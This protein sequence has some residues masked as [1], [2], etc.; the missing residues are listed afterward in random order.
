MTFLAV[1]EDAVRRQGMDPGAVTLS[2]AEQ[3]GLAKRIEKWLKRGWRSDWWP[4]L[5]VV[6]QREYRATWAVGTTYAADAE[7]YY[8]DGTDEGYFVSL[9]GTNVGNTPSFA[10]ATAWWEEA[11][12]DFVSYVDFDQSWETNEIDS[13][14][15]LGHVFDEDP[16][17]HAESAPLGWCEVQGERL[18]VRY[19]APVRPWLKFRKMPPQFTRTAYAGG[20]TYAA[21]AVVYGSDG[22]C[23]RSLAG[24]NTG[25]TPS[26]SPTWWEKQEFPEM[27]RDYVVAGVYGDWVRDDE[28]RAMSLRDAKREL[29]ELRDRF[30]V[31]VSGALEVGWEG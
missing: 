24:S 12:D 29:E 21:D 2:T 23:Y 27:F 1:Y 6:E 17:V 19:D 10:G 8:T 22:E 18:L 15:P 25:H 9:A 7:V 31:Q 30:M 3:E 16:R 14:D 4:Q 5:M 13:L 28:E 11:G 26:S 20:T